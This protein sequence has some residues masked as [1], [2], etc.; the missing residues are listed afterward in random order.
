MRNR[1][2][3]VS[4]GPYIIISLESHRRQLL[5]LPS[6]HQSGDINVLA[7]LSSFDHH[8]LF[9][10]QYLKTVV[11]SSPVFAKSKDRGKHDLQSLYYH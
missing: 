5:E 6:A 3:V 2:S 11:S 1:R 7:A 8:K 9:H 10:Q 4:S